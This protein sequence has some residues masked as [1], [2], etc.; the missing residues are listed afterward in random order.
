VGVAAKEDRSRRW[1]TESLLASGPLNPGLHESLLTAELNDLVSAVGTDGLVAEVAELA[2]AEASDRV[3]RHLGR[4]IAR[5]IE[6]APERDRSAVA[7]RIAAE[8]IDRLEKL[9][10]ETLDLA[11]DLPLDPGSVLLAVLRRLPDGTPQTIERPLTPLLDT[12]V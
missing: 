7:I 3:A 1:E 11:G 9:S 2:N 6:A 12:T 5:A 4:L 8:L 10:D